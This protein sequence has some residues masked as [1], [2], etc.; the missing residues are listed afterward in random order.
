MKLDPYLTPITKINLKRGKRLRLGLEGKD[1]TTLSE[2]SLKKKTN[3]I[4]YHFYVEI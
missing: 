3:T 2:I 4:A 1:I